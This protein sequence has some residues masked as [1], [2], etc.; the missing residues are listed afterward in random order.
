MA[1]RTR[2]GADAQIFRISDSITDQSYFFELIMD[3]LPLIDTNR[4]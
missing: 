4:A 1:F 2:D 3:Q